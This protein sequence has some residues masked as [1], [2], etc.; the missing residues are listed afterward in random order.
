MPLRGDPEGYPTKD[1]LADYLEQYAQSFHLPVQTGDGVVRLE[2][3]GRHFLAHTATGQ[4]VT[5]WA[6]VVATGA[7]HQP[8]VPAYARQLTPDVV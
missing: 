6:V 7:F 1:E 3:Q 2:R 4:P 5:A 8:M